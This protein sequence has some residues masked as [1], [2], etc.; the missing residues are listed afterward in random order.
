[1]DVKKTT[2]KH[3]LHEVIFESNTPAG[4]TFD[5]ALLICILCSIVVVILDSVPSY[6]VAY[7]KE[8]LIIEWCFTILFTIEYILRLASVKWPIRYAL[9][10]LGLIDLLP[11]SPCTLV[12]FIPGPSHC[13][14]FAPYA[15]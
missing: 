11:L 15:Y 5:V 3:R 8:F 9:G 12:Y 6:H 13:W 4:K 2:W 1:M 7:G 10:F 14:Y